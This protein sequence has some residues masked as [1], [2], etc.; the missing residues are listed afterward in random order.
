MITLRRSGERRHIPGRGQ[1]TWMTFNPESLQD[2]L[3]LGFRTLEALNEQM[4][5]PGIGFLIRPDRNT[6]MFTYVQQGTLVQEDA[7]GRTRVL[8]RGECRC[9]TVGS[10]TTHRTV[11]GSLTEYAHAF[12][13][14]ITP[15]R[16]DLYRRPQQKRFPVAERRGILRLTASPQGIDGSLRMHQDIRVYSSLLDPGHHLIHELACRRAAWLHVVSGRI[17]LIEHRLGSGDGACL[18]EEPAASWTALEPSEI[19]LFDFA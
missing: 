16:E 4:L 13:C 5:A 10:G 2:P 18:V 11:N 17:Q 14:C 15:D 7:S 3:R 6:E 12:Q 9:S 1:D 19:L 8:E